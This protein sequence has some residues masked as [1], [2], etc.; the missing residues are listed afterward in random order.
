[1]ITLKGLL[2]VIKS[3]RII[4]VNLYDTEEILRISFDLPGFAALEDK[5]E[6]SEVTGIEIVNMTTMNVYI[7]YIESGE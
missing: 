7:D 3:E 6:E 1:M 5:L 4:K 2:S